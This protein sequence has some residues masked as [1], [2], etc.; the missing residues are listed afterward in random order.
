MLLVVYS[1]FAA[2]I[3]LPISAAGIVAWMSIARRFRWI[4]ES[5][6]G[7][8]TTALVIASAVVLLM[9]LSFDDQSRFSALSTPLF[10]ATW[11]GLLA[12]RLVFVRL[13]PGQ[14]L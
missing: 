14:L 11:A 5:V 10:V 3:V 12:P 2:L 7:I 1:A 13:R 6:L 9:W 8:A 4:E